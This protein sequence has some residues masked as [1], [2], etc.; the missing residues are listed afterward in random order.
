LVI[1]IL[2]VVHGFPPKNLAGT[3]IYTYF[4][5]KE[6]SRRHDVHVFYPTYGK[7]AYSV[8]HFVRDGLTLHELSLPYNLTERIKKD[9]IYRSTYMN[10]KVEEKFKQTLDKVAPDIVHFQ[11]LINLSASLIE[12]TKG[13]GIPIVLTL[14]DYWFIC[15]LIQLLTSDYNICTGPDE[16][17]KNCFECW[18]KRKVEFLANYLRKWLIPRKISKKILDLALRT[19]NRKKDFEQ[20]KKYMKLLLLKVDKI[21]TPSKFLKNFFI[22]HGIP[23]EKIIFSENGYNLNIFGNFEKKKKKKI[24]FGFVGTIQKHKGVDVLIEAF[25]KIDDQ[26]VELRIYGDYDMNSSYFKELKSKIKNP[27]IKFMGRFEDIKEPYSEIDILV[28]PSIWYET[29]GPLVVKEAFATKTPIIGSA[30]G[31]IP[32]FVKHNTTGLLFKAGDSKDLYEKI[33]MV[34]EDPKIIER[35]KSNIKLPKS[36]KEQAVEIE[37]IYKEVIENNKNRRERK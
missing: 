22:G 34:L 10:K 35:F 19:I 29:G 17:A 8:K 11:H 4:L 9:I 16:Q 28:V 14:H 7:N 25:N 20:R 36:I 18:N 30:L 27:N 26:N 23:K 15:P 12:V 24:T 1:R 33:K 3:E 37:R 32:E 31:C 2:Q 13:K 5:S 6:L 21:I